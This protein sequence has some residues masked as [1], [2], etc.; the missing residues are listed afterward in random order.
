MVASKWFKEM[1]SFTTHLIIILLK[2][3]YL[4]QDGTNDANIY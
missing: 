4:A 2:K 3:Y 1:K